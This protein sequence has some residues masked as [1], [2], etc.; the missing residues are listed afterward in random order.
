MK[1]LK[2]IVATAVIVF[3]LTTVAMAGVRQF[4]GGHSASPAAVAPTATAPQTQA[5][6][7]V[8]LSAQQFAQLLR[9]TSAGTARRPA[10]HRDRDGDPSRSHTHAAG[11]DS[12]H[13]DAAHGQYAS[14]SGNAGHGSG[15]SSSH[16]SADQHRVI[17]GGSGCDTADGHTSGD[18][19]GGCE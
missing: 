6:A 17:T 1:A 13:N 5:Q 10:A 11:A 19:D 15:S 8:T 16:S 4:G 14:A 2:T 12:H 9:A 7:T 18:H 3:A